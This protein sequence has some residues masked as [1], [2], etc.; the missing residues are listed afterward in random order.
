MDELKLRKILG[1]FVDTFLPSLDCDGGTRFVA[2]MLEGM[3]IDFEIFQ[4]SICEKE[5][6]KNVFPI[7]IWL[8]TKEKMNIFDFKTKKWLGVEFD[9]VKYF[10]TQKM[11]KDKFLDVGGSRATI[12]GL[13]TFY[14]MKNS[15]LTN[16]IIGG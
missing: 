6:S 12:L 5:N 16:K 1:D 2:M 15:D 8:V 14:G 3:G 4:G 7:H 10:N 9:K 13:L 11:D